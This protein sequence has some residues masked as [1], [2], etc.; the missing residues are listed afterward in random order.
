MS[1]EQQYS[2]EIGES[3]TSDAAMKYSPECASVAGNECSLSEDLHC[4]I[5]DM[6]ELDYVSWL[7]V[8]LRTIRESFSSMETS[9]LPVRAAKLRPMLGALEL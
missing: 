6:S 2:S 4:A 5:S 8:G 7:V 1:M 9:P 3:L